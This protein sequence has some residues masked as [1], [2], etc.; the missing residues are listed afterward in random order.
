MRTPPGAND[1]VI[2]CTITRQECAVES[3]NAATCARYAPAVT[4]TATACATPGQDPTT[5]CSQ[6]YCAQPAGVKYPYMNCTASGNDVTDSPGTT[7]TVHPVAG[8]CSTNVVPSGQ[9][10]ALA[11]FTQRSLSCRLSNDRQSCASFTV[12]TTPTITECE[13]FSNLAGID[14]L[15][16]PSGTGVRSGTESIA[17]VVLN[18]PSCPL[19]GD[20]STATKALTAG[21]IGTVVGGGTSTPVTLSSGFAT[22][23]TFCDSQTEHCSPSIDRLRA[24]LADA[25]VAGTQVRNVVATNRG[26]IVLSGVPDPDS[27]AQT[28]AAGGVN[29][30]LRGL[31]N[32]A[33]SFFLATNASPWSA[34]LS[35]GNLNLR[36][37]LD[38][39]VTDANGQPLSV[40]MNVNVN[41]TPANSAQQGCA[42]LSPIGRLFGFEDP[43]NWSSSNAA[44]SLVTS[45]ITQGCGALGIT[46]QGFMA[47]NGAGFSTVGLNPTV[48]VS[49][50][51]FVPS[52][53]PNP[54]WTGA[55]Q[56]YLS[57]PSGNVFNQFIGQVEL[58]GQP[59]NR[60]STLRFPLPAATQS[61]L[62]QPLSDCAFGFALNVNQTNRKWILDNL[63]FT[64]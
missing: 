38:L 28:V 49:V 45:P 21:T 8:I 16:P 11:T 57:C 51:L 53:Q 17:S 27:G 3:A 52:S 43:L 36:G 9:R 40:T 14:L 2:T 62:A 25:T 55:L 31:V 48:A 19:V 12:N 7:P 34:N 50:D 35:G 32:G 6:S 30:A 64:P 22:V 39:L 60:Y 4:L 63:R 54:F 47:I 42:A 29:L 23:G 15:K 41:G 59:Q 26:P 37:P 33:D 1:R 58:T 44:L 5:A 61:T 46:G 24:N 10:Y 20:T 18:S 13:D 56:M